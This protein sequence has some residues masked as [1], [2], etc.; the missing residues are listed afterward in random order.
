MG[1]KVWVCIYLIYDL[2]ECLHSQQQKVSRQQGFASLVLGQKLMPQV[3]NAR[4]KRPE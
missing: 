1:M 4:A 2:G 3:E